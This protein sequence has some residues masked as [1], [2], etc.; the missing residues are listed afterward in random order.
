MM[1]TNGEGYYPSHYGSLPYTSISTHH[2]SIG[3]GAPPPP[4]PPPSSSIPLYYNPTF[5]YDSKNSLNDEKIPSFKLYDLETNPQS[6]LIRLIFSYADISYKDKHLKEDAWNKIKEQTSIEQLPILR[7][8]KHYKIYHFYAIIRYLAREFHLYGTGQHEHTIVDM[9]IEIIRPLQEKIFEQLKNSNDHEEKLREIIT[10][11]LTIY[12]K[13]LENIYNIFNR[14]GPFYLGSRISLADLIVYHTINYLIKIDKKLLEN[15]SHLKETYKRLEK[16]PGV[17]KYI[18]KK[19]DKRSKTSDRKSSSQSQRNRTKSP[20][21]NTTSSSQHHH[22]RH[23]RHHRHRSHE[24]HKAT[25][26]HHHHRHHHRQHSKEATPL[27]Q[28]KQS[29]VR[30]S[31]SPSISKKEKERPRL[32]TTDTNLPPSLT[33]DEKSESVVD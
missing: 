13:P 22:H 19:N 29:S 2:Y 21:P 16:H 7:I 28:K 17:S 14:H 9:I 30:S 18:S 11:S 20:T 32:K 1:I 4:P 26:H 33:T 27:S 8:N 25:H 5:Q 23:H 24:G 31:K 3:P 10:N 15:Y 6:D 12:L